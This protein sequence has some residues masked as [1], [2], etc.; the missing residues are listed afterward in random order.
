MTMQNT[1]T[2]TVSSKATLDKAECTNTVIDTKYKAF[3]LNKRGKGDFGDSYISMEFKYTNNNNV[4][5]YKHIKARMKENDVKAKYK[6]NKLDSPGYP[7]GLHL[8]NKK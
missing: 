1:K 2:I 6:E 8:K 4:V 7:G 5:M 3:C